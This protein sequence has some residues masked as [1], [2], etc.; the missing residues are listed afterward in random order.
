MSKYVPLLKKIERLFLSLLT[1][2][3]EQNCSQ[4]IQSVC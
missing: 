3:R 2:L 1:R 4:G